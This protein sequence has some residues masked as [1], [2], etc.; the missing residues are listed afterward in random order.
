MDEEGKK[1]DLISLG[2]FTIDFQGLA[3]LVWLLSEKY[4]AKTIEI[5]VLD[6]SV[7]GSEVKNG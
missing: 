1:E 7:E 2:Y 5:F 6:K 3:F 4:D